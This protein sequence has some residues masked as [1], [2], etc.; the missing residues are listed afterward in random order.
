M[1]DWFMRWIAGRACA[2]SMRPTRLLATGN[3]HCMRPT[4]LR[5]YRN[6]S[7]QVGDIRI[8]IGRRCSAMDRLLCAHASREAAFITAYNPFSRLMPPGWNQ[9][10][11]KRL[12]GA[13]RRRTAL[14]ATGSLRGWSETHLLV[15]GDVR[16]IRR[17]ARR[18][19]Q[20]AIV[21]V[22]LQQPARLVPTL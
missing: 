9:R 13:V 5:A 6:T 20:N 2:K 17:L 10:M 22:R 16:P 15:L 19:R 12:A 14:P 3:E 7:Y 4:L 21:T 18:Y 1:F 11:Q 8:R